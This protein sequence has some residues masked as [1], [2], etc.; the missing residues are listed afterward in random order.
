MQF[1]YVHVYAL[2]VI[3]EGILGTCSILIHILRVELLSTSKPLA[4]PQSLHQSKINSDAVC[5]QYAL[6]KSA[7]GGRT[8]LF[9]CLF[10]AHY[11]S[12]QRAWMSC[13]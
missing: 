8:A 4:P 2:I 7:G 5:I 9:R 10:S 3:I 6:N 11:S 13:P 1:L 12:L